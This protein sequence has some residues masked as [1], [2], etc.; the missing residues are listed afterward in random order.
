MLGQIRKKI[1]E[2][3]FRIKLRNS[4]QQETNECLRITLE[5]T[6]KEIARRNKQHK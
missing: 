1:S 6:K 4:L 5:E 3:K 2:T